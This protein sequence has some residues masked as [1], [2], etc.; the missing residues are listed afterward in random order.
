[1]KD[2]LATRL[3][4]LDELTAPLS[5]QSVYLE[6]KNPFYSATRDVQNNSW[7]EYKSFVRASDLQ[8]QPSTR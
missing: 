5:Q 4:D 3:Q 2:N 6:I 8:A 1:M 7:Q